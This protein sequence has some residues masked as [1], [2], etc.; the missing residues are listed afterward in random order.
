MNKAVLFDLDGTLLDTERDFTQI[1]NNQLTSSGLPPKSHLEVRNTVSSG[2]RALVMLG[3]GIDEDHPQ[4]PVYLDE[5]LERYLIRI[6]QTESVL[7][8]GIANLLG[9]LDKDASPWGIVTNKPS[10]FALPLV[11]KFSALQNSAVVICSDQLSNSKPDPEGI[12]L[13]CEK[14]QCDPAQ[15]IYVGDHPKDVQAASAA[16]AMSIGVRWGYIPEDQPIETW[17]ADLI[18]NHPDDILDYLS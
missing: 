7:F 2:A 17:N 16:G 11:K 3:F 6:P 12:L 9:A 8:P 1:L 14:M 5:L 4:F 18:I 13:A 10:R 15:V